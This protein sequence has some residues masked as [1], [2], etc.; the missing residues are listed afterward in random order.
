M[1]FEKIFRVS[2]FFFSEFG[3]KTVQLIREPVSFL[4][5]FGGRGRCRF[6]RRSTSAGLAFW[7]DQNRSRKMGK[8][9]LPFVKF[10]Y[11]LLIGHKSQKNRTGASG[12]VRDFGR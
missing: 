7:R 10:L 6:D 11:V 8:S 12:F 9:H 4:N 2:Q 1:A 3:P 5:H